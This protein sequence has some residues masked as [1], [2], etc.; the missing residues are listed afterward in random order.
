MIRHAEAPSAGQIR[1]NDL[2]RNFGFAVATVGGSRGA[3]GSGARPGQRMVL[4]ALLAF[5][6]LL[7]LAAPAL[8]APPAVTTGE[9][10]NRAAESVTLNG[11][12]NPGG[13]AVT[14]CKFEY[15]K[16]TSYGQ[17]APCAESNAS[18]GTGTSPVAVHADVVG[19]AHRASY[20]YRLVAGNAD[21]TSNGK[22]RT[23]ATRGAQING[24]TLVTV[25]SDSAV[26]G[27][28]INPAG[29][30]T[31]YEFQYVAD[32]EFQSSGYLFATGLPAGGQSI[33]AGSGD[34][35]V[36]QEATG[37]TP[38]TTY[39]F[40]VVATSPD[41][42]TVGED[43]AFTT[44]L[45]QATG[46]PDGRAYEQASP[47]DKNGNSVQGSLNNV[48]AA[49]DGRG[50]I[51][52]ANGGMPGGEG[53]QDYPTYLALRGASSWTNHGLLASASF[54][55]RSKVYGL[56]NDFSRSF[57]SIG[58][59]GIE[60]GVAETNTATGQ[61]TP[62]YIES[63]FEF[64]NEGAYIGSSADN[65]KSVFE[66]GREILPGAAAGYPNVYLWDSV[67]KKLVLAGVLN[68]GQA[69]EEGAF[70]GSY[71]WF[72][73]GET[74]WGGG[75]LKHYTEA[76]HVVSDDGTQVV[77]TSGGAAQLYVRVNATQPQS[78]VDGE[79]NCTVPTDA[80]TL[81][82]SKSVRTIP[83]PAGQKP[84]KFLGASTDGSKIFFMSR[85][86]LTND[87]NTGV[88]DAGQDL[89]RYEPKTQT[90]VDLTANSDP[91][92][93]D[94][95]NVLGLLGT[96]D[97]G[98]YVYFAATGVL[99]PGA[100]LGSINIYL[101]HNGVITFVTK[102]TG[103]ATEDDAVSRLW[104]PT[105][106]E[107]V[108]AQFPRASRVA[109]D[110]QT[111]IFK[112][113]AKLTGYDNKGISQVY[114]YRVGEGII[115][116]SCNPTGAPPTGRATLQSVEAAGEFIKPNYMQGTFPRNLS[117]S[118]DQVFF[119]TRDQLIAPDNNGV[120]DVYEWEANGAGSCQSS[121]QNGGCLYLLSTGTSPKPSFFGDASESGN[122]VFF[123][124]A[125]PLVIQD[126][127]ELVDV[128]D[129]R[130][131]GG[132][133]S[134]NPP[135]PSICT[136]EG[137]RPE[138]TPVP[139]APSPGTSSFVGQPDPKPHRRKHHKKKHHKKKHH[140]KR[141]HKKKHHS[142]KGH[143]GSKATNRGAHR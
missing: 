51:F 116:V 132:L 120:Q 117:V 106:A 66:L 23:F 121:S 98:S 84:A 76:Q 93:P 12:L 90:L 14:S 123:F 114:R 54:G 102:A 34:V 15:G 78:P 75:F 79:G 63:S 17:T 18:I 125:Q 67:A 101:A 140:K 64:E 13:A 20:H 30:A 129:A 61:V 95:A 65:T 68:N 111:V 37:L 56:S 1:F 112:S 42:Q 108:G 26:F 127:D 69:P 81:K 28:L 25:R 77:F 137:C 44:Y 136:G 53:A 126:R 122:D 8:A 41:G 6:A 96:S 133:A 119:E 91:G 87:A 48:R 19:L 103:G 46:L 104:A 115:C 55:S 45:P 43:L 143:D 60:N 118:G 3:T 110:G 89:Y 49:S 2:S 124:T 52:F 141:H 38:L 139:E 88:A 142:G 97:D 21:G 128:Y 80:C 73:S 16:T 138:T 100:T 22:D 109:P 107:V 24:Q 33:G 32:A 99:A 131:G 11:T 135:P 59:P 70:A 29:E 27:A 113:T 82:V 71:E 35:V 58:T 31:T 134:Q 94:G 57:M 36:S 92:N 5:A 39:H 9:I 40:R 86:Q 74:W 72:A 50:V 83:D 7:V 10:S 105:D 47:L 130:V 4:A 62:I 85:S